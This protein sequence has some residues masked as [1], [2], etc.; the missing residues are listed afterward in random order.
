MLI[1][2][3]IAPSNGETW[4]VAPTQT[5]PFQQ[6]FGIEVLPGYHCVGDMD[7]FP[8]L[9]VDDDSAT[10]IPTACP[11]TTGVTGIRAYWLDVP[12]ASLTERVAT[13]VDPPSE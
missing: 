6:V 12:I 7:I 5:F 1:R 4:I 13:V 10:I 8:T 3:Q 9:Y 11:L 2:I